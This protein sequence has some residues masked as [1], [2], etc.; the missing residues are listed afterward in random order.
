[1]AKKT[2][3][4]QRTKVAG[5]ASNNIPTE[6]WLPWA[7]AALSLFLFSTGFKNEM[8]AIDD[9]TATINNPAVTNFDIFSNFNLGM[10]APLTWLG[11]AIA[12][13][14]GE[15]SSF[16]YHVFSALVH[17]ANV[18]LVFQLFRQLH[19]SLTVAGFIA[20]FFAIHPLQVEPVAWI[21]G[22]STPLYAMFYLLALRFYVRHSLQE[23]LEK[24]Y[25]MA[26]GMFFLACLSK[27]AAVALPLTLLVVDL[28][29]KR[30]QNRRIWI[31]KIPFFALSLAFGAL[32]LVS[33]QHAPPLDQPADFSLLD[34]ALMVCHTILF[35]WKMIVLP[36]GLSIWYPFEKTN[37]AWGWAYYASPLLLA[38]ILY[39][40]WRMRAS[41]PVLWLGLLFFLTNVVL[42]LP[43]ATF[44]SFELRSD[45]YNYVACLGIFA[46]ITALPTYFSQKRPNLVGP[47]W[48]VLVLSGVIWLFTSGARIMEWKDTIT[49]ID[50][51]IATNGDNFGKAYLSRGII[52]ADQGKGD[53]A[54]QDFNK[55]INKNALL[56]D[57]YKYRGNI[58]GLR[59]NYEQ[60]VFDLTKY[61]EYFPEASPEIYN[62]GLSYV[63][64][65]KDTEALAD[66]NRCL[67]IDSTFTRAYRARGNTYLKLGETAKGDADLQ[68]YDR[69]TKK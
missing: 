68:K 16:W 62:R 52:L 2:S 23:Q 3:T 66:F 22:F 69:L 20:F 10:Y 15:D 4:A 41:M 57:V 50:S 35:Y 25:W 11:Y 29:L 32:T 53:P 37:G 60:S 40:A 56:V 55:A 28:W 49:L 7:L 26:L 19:T 27:S 51:A 58:M 14:L 54:L 43:W 38:A 21:S 36:T 31:E 47:M 8:L 67:E 6:K 45:R 12:Y 48:G 59:K 44:G 33:R 42:S 65:G 13:L 9:H 61:I 34:R 17:A 5:N 63:N 46:I 30:G 18:V 39:I 64:L 1:M 24:N